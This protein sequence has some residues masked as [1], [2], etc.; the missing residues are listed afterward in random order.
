MNKIFLQKLLDYYHIT[1]E[2]YLSLK[3]DSFLHDFDEGM[4]FD[5]MDEAVRLVKTAISNKAK[6]IIYGDYD[7]DGIMSTSI[8]KKMFEMVGYHVDFYIPTR[9]KDGYGINI[10]K[11]KEFAEKGYNLV[12]TVDNGVNAIEPIAFL[13]NEGIDVLVIDHHTNDGEL[14]NANYII[15]PTISHFSKINSSAGFTS[16]M[17]ASAF[18]NKRDKYL[19][20]L[21][22]ISTITDMMPLLEHNRRFLKS[23]FPLYKKGEFS[24][25]DLLLENEDFNETSIGLK[26]GPRIN[27]IGRLVEDNSINDIVRYFT[28]YNYDEQ[29]NY[30]SVINAINEDRRKLSK[31]SADLLTISANDIAVCEILD[32]K[33]GMI[34][35]VA[36]SLTNKYNIPSIIFTDSINGTIKGSIR[37][38]EWFNVVD[39]FNKLKQYLETSGGHTAAGGCSMKKE[40]FQAFKNAFFELV[41]NTPHEKIEKVNIPLQITDFTMENYEIV[42][43]LSP[44]GEAWK[45]PLFSL[46]GVRTT[47][48]TYSKNNAHIMTQIG[49]FSRIVGFNYSKEEMSNYQIVNLFGT[50]RTSIFR[51]INNLE[52]LINE[53]IPNNK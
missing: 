34:G 36:G 2:D 23:V 50:L 45:T 38:P 51:N 42:K 11:A 17:F 21:A 10:D 44:F 13:R 26:I 15:H 46:K 19:A 14:P 28:E 43:E 29:L 7:A 20:I 24:Q 9:Y 18:L 22:T 41:K 25:L 47:A 3:K 32:L 12:I 52:F 5:Y 1:Y 33:E 49:G 6:I 8:I 30:I 39:C 48:L 4:K 40:N 27:S 37:S 31:E 35:L 16:F 53:V